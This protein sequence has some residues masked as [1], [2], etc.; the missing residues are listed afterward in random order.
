MKVIKWMSSVGITSDMAYIATAASV[1]LSIITWTV[2]RGDDTAN[3]ERF[4][5]FV[6]LWAPTLAVMGRALEE[7]ERTINM[8]IEG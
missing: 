7:E 4:G 2:R 8:N 5:I 6:G 3:A 1:L